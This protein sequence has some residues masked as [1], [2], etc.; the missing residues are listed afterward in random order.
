MKTWFS[1]RLGDALTA[2]LPT[3]QIKASFEPLHAAAGRPADMAVFTRI[4]SEGRLHCDVTAF[5]SPASAELARTF[6]APPCA[7]PGRVGLE[8]LA[9]DQRS[10]CVLFPAHAT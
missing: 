9:G 3:T 10:W 1:L 2:Q 6:D 8:L 5:F 4:D 7:R